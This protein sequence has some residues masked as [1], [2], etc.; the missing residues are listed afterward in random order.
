MSDFEKL[1]V[2]SVTKEVEKFPVEISLLVLLAD[3]LNAMNLFRGFLNI[4]SVH[5][6]RMKCPTL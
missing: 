4:T 1:S 6:R 2:G 3:F 5:L